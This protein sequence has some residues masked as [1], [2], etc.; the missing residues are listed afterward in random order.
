MPAFR[1]I[2]VTEKAGYAQRFPRFS[3][4]FLGGAFAWYGIGDARR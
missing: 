3:V 4:P 1:V 2:L